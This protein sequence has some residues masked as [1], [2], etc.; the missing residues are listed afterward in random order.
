MFGPLH[1]LLQVGSVIIKWAT[2][3]SLV[4]PSYTSPRGTMLV[5]H[6]QDQGEWFTS[7][8]KR[9]VSIADCSNNHWRKK[10]RNSV[11][12]EEGSGSVC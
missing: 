5:A 6:V 7:A 1:A 12:T 3:Q 10:K 11:C 9:N 2:R 4:V 8:C